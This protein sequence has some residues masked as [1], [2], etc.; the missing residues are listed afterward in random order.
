MGKRLKVNLGC[1]LRK[2]KGWYGIDI[3]DFK[4]VDC[5]M[6]IGEEKLPFED[7]SVD[8]IKAIHVLEHLY[9]DELF[10]C[11]EECFRVL[12]PKGFFKIEVP[13]AGTPAYYINPDHKI[14]FV[15]D[16]FGFFQVP[17]EGIDP[18]GYLKGF[19][20]VQ[21]LKNENPEAITV[22]MY[23]NKPNG[24]FDYVKV[25]RIIDRDVKCC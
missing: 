21:I 4:G 8:Q 14:Q 15:E 22:K 9:P 23:P 2:D 11:I 16:T 1:G 12:K 6:N 7:N 3:R 25:K 20:H 5:V 18:H 10:F 19:W 13:K 24:K 17:S